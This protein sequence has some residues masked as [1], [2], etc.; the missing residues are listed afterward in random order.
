MADTT[1]IGAAGEVAQISTATPANPNTLD[2]YFLTVN[3]NTVSF[4][5]AGTETVAAVTAGLVAAWNASTYVE[6]TE[7]TAV[8]STTLVTLTADTAG[9]P[10]TA[11]SA[12]T[13]G[14]GGSAPTLTMATP[15][16][17]TGPN[18]WS[19][20]AN[21]DTGAVP[22][23]SDVV[24]IENT[25]VDILHGLAQSAV[26]LTALNVAASYTGNIGLAVTNPAGYPEYRATY[27]AIKATAVDIGY[28]DGSGSSRI[29]LDLS[30][31]QS[32]IN[33]HATGS[34]S[35]GSAPALVI[36]GTHASNVA[37]VLSGEVG[38]G[39]YGGEAVTVATLHVYADSV[40]EVGASATITT[41]A[42]RGDGSLVMRDNATT[43]VV[44]GGT[45]AYRDD[46]GAV[47]TLTINSGSVEYYSNQTITTLRVGA[48]AIF[49]VPSLL[50]TS[51]PTVTNC[52]VAALSEIADP[53]GQIT[54]SN[55]II[56]DA[57]VS[58]ADI[59]LDV[60]AGRTI[61]AS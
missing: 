52:T 7:V 29:K 14:A 54:N 35:D 31:A 21:W 57:G 49:A 46:D 45:V 36:K 37:T 24:W 47:T 2:V 51:G 28:G 15:T 1:W 42:K 43:I 9:L 26:T 34:G 40:V 61:T 48:N 50:G 17:A 60:G 44:D 38:F 3:G 8:D 41:V 22:V 55:G 11:T 13:D 6:L 39:Y 12:I 18:H 53:F 16:A 56:L 58:L 5:V 59:I 25:A 4:T 19:D 30:T 10:F 33:V 20:A 27:L 32:A 23:N